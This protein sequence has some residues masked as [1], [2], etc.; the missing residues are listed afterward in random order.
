MEKIKVDDNKFNKIET[1]QKYFKNII[2]LQYIHNTG[3][4]KQLFA[5]TYIIIKEKRN[6]K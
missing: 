3:R 6:K 4:R 1:F 2:D 5:C